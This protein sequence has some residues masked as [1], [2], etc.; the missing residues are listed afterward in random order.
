MSES[1]DDLIEGLDS[2]Q[3]TSTENRDHQLELEKIKGILEGPKAYGEFLSRSGSQE[4]DDQ[5]KHKFIF[6]E[7]E[8]NIYPY[9]NRLEAISNLGVDLDHED[10]RIGVNRFLL[11]KGQIDSTTIDLLND[12]NCD[13]DNSFKKLMAIVE[14]PNS[15]RE[16]LGEEGNGQLFEFGD[17][18]INL[19][20]YEGRVKALEKSGLRLDEKQV[21]ALNG[22]LKKNKERKTS[23]K[24]FNDLSGLVSALKT[25]YKPLFAEHNNENL[26]AEQQSIPTS[27]LLDDQP[28]LSDNT[29][30]VVCPTD[31]AVQ[32]K[33]GRV[34]ITA[35]AVTTVVLGTAFLIT[36]A[37]NYLG[38]G[39]SEILDSDIAKEP[40]VAADTQYP[41]IIEPVF[42]L[43]P[44]N[45]EVDLVSIITPTPTI[46]SLD[47]IREDDLGLTAEYD[48][49]SNNTFTKTIE[50]DVSTT[51][52]HLD[53]SRL[54]AEIRRGYHNLFVNE[55]GFNFATPYGEKPVERKMIA[56]V[57][58]P[59]D[60]DQR[61]IYFAMQQIT[62][63]ILDQDIVNEIGPEVQKKV[64]SYI[65]RFKSDDFK[66]LNVSRDD[67]ERMLTLLELS[68]YSLPEVNMVSIYKNEGNL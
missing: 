54:S 66:K 36:S 41:N 3:N 34:L 56:A 59:A 9:S 4:T 47:E 63:L 33:K 11:D 24:E 10:V 57:E 15:Y 5:I 64:E 20:R 2:L 51:K 8:L 43:T 7:K 13:E 46:E 40:T 39:K 30:E 60:S 6:G 16:F 38:C 32:R 22:Y 1:L 45:D 68:G 31:D 21:R 14:G 50:V 44:P 55:N 67:L 12:Y 27:V 62:N 37:F 29:T 48:L 18:K 58:L 42:E 26:T 61:D 65:D 53:P 23:K 49:D 17:E 52:P 25:E 35:G 19:H 28:I